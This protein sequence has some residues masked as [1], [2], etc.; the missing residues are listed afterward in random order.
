M[1][2]NKTKKYCPHCRAEIDADKVYCPEC[3]KLTPKVKE[4]QEQPEKKVK[5]SYSRKCPECGSIIN[6]NVLKQCP[7]CD[8]ELPEPPKE[9]TQ[10]E[11]KPSGL[12]F[13]N[14]KFV[15]EA[16]LK[17]K[18]DSWNF[19][20]GINV[21]GN[22][23]MVYVTITLLL[24]LSL[25]FYFTQIPINIFTLLLFMVPD[26][27]F[28]IYVI[29]YIY[30]RNHN[31]EKIGL[32]SKTEKVLIGL[33]IGLVGSIGIYFLDSFSDLFLDLFSALGLGPILS[34]L[35]ASIIAQN[36]AIKTANPFMIIVFTILLCVSSIS[37]EIVFRGVLH[38]TL[39]QR[40]GKDLSSRFLVI[41]IVATAYSLIYLLFS[42]P[43]GLIF[44]ISNFLISLL[45]G[46]LYEI[47]GNLYNT[48]FAN[49][50]Y[51]IAIVL[52]ILFL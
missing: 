49:I 29:Y 51:N 17:L 1:S 41:I 47:N 11:E 13:T 2:D 7:V 50:Y 30:S 52:I 20:E 19:K 36:Q 25:S 31:Y 37:S 23:I 3:G 4:I 28:S 43:T 48:I 40:I 34:N 35:E 26:V 33:G 12:I 18:K 42:F 45:L 27:L 5:K 6:S 44:I 39:K 14:K 21:F 15:S 9:V 32:S 22:S 16:K 38:N 10:K 8:A 24:Y 46:I